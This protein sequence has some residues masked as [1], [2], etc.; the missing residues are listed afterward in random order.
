MFKIDIISIDD[1]YIKH[2]LKKVKCNVST[3]TGPFF[4]YKRSGI[5]GFEPCCTELRDIGNSLIQTQYICKQNIDIMSSKTLK[6]LQCLYC[7]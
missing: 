5:Q 1:L 3:E 6:C 2:V 7:L 4:S